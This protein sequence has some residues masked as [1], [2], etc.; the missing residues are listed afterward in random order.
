M[1][2]VFD[3]GGPLVLYSV[4]RHDG[5]STVSA[6]ILSGIFPAFGVVLNYVRDRRLDA[7]GALVLV[8]IV[9]GTILGVVSGSARLVLMEG[10]VPTA[11]FGVVCLVS[12]RSGRPLIY[13]FAVE[14]IGPHSPQGQEFE[15]LWEQYDGF[16]R[17][18]RVMT[19]VWGTAY[20]LEAVARVVIVESTSTGTALAISKVM[21]Y[22]VAGLLVA[23]TMAYGRMQRRRGERLAA[24]AGQAQVQAQPRTQ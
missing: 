18:W 9:V 10:S 6:L 8:G 1:I 3:V 22:A 24:E 4:L 16:R 11:V 13:R 17:I 2:A 14:F 12:L 15:R 23:W 19:V 5:F 20:L 21:P 7:I